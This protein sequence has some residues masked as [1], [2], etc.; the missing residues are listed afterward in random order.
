MQTEQSRTTLFVT[1]QSKKLTYWDMLTQLEKKLAFIQCPNTEGELCMF[2]KLN[3]QNNQKDLL[4]SHL[5]I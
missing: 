2:G 1:V 4:N 3:Y 5:A